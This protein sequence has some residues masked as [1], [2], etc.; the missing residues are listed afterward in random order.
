MCGIA[1]IIQL[2]QSGITPEHSER[3]QKMTDRMEKRGPDGMGFYKTERSVLGHR[4]L[5]IIDLSDRAKQPMF[6]E[7]LGIALVFNGCIYNYQ[8]LKKA[9]EDKGYDFF[10]DSD[11]E[12]IIKAYHCWGEQCLDHFNGMFAFCLVELSSGKA[13]LARDRLGIKPLYY[14]VKDDELIFCSS[15]TALIKANGLQ[16]TINPVAL[17]TYLSF[18]SIVPSPHTIF[19]EV[20]KLPPAYSMTIDES[21]NIEKSAYWSMSFITPG[22]KQAY[23]EEDWLGELDTAM[24]K[25]VQRRLV[26]D[27]PVGVLLSG[28]LDSSLITALLAHEG[29][30]SLETFSI[31]FESVNGESG[32]EFQYSDLVARHFGT[33]HHRLEISDTGTMDALQAAIYAM[34]EPMVSHDNVGFFLLSKEVARYVKVVQSGQ[35]ADEVFAGYHWYPPMQHGSD[36]L[37]TYQQHFFDR[38]YQEYL[39]TVHPGW[40]V[41]DCATAFV[42]DHFATPGA[43]NPVDKALRL[44]MSVMLVEDPVKRVDSQ[45]M[46]WGLEA[47]VPFLDH[48]LIELAA[49]MPASYKL[50]HDGKGILKTLSRKYLPADVIDRP[51]GYFPVPALKYLDGDFLGF[52]EDALRSKQATERG[53]FNPDYVALLLNDPGGHITNLGGSKLWQLGLLE[54]WLQEHGF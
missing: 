37:A 30:S 14:T 18:H 24:K 15:L 27:V 51:K 16:T 4:R 48:E 33:T 7:K 34:N 5:K 26:A 19:N 3:V 44:D 50:A 36:A 12:I 53:I 43:E 1:G 42:Q 28:G 11:T 41:E 8:S 35:G 6:D 22:E 45:T 40:Q 17:N 46:A 13:F 23:T 32:N 52:V 38:D 47:R 25:A 9:L 54:I 21:G 2:T 39:N 49:Q 31:G 10:S 20:Q 29:A